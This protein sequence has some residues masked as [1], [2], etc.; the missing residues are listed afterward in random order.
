M[1]LYIFR[2]YTQAQLIDYIADAKIEDMYMV[3]TFV[4]SVCVY[5][6]YKTWDLGHSARC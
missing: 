2:A 1:L 4:Y 3:Y 6:Q 5:V